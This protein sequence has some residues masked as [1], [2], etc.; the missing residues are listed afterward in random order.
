MSAD[1]QAQGP[2]VD[3]TLAMPSFEQL[4][5]IEQLAQ[6]HGVDPATVELDRPFHLPEGW[7][8][9]KVAGRYYTCSPT[10]NVL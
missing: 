4:T 10:G 6:R 1:V 5:A 8:S 9:L 3:A 2:M 7:L